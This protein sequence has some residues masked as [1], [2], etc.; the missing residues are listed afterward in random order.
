MLADTGMSETAF[1]AWA[2]RSFSSATSCLKSPARLE[3]HRFGAR[4]WTGRIIFIWGLATVLLGFTI[5][6]KMFYL[7]RFLL[8]AA[9]AGFYP[10]WSIISRCGFPGRTAG[11]CSG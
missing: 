9:E 10:G 4:V 1:T 6:A 11:E 2:P 7:L 5:N 8:G 3:R